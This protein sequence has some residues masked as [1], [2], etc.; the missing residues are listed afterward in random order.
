MKKFIGIIGSPSIETTN[1]KLLSL[2]K[3]AFQSEFELEL[4]SVRD[5]PMFN[6]PISLELPA[7]IQT[8][9]DKIDTADGVLISTAEYDHSVPAVLSNALA[10]LSYG[11]YPMVDK[12]TLILGTSYGRLGSSRAQFH[13]R[14]MLNAPQLAANMMSGD[15]YLL[16]HALR[17]FTDDSA[18]A[19]AI[20]RTDLETYINRFIEFV[21]HN[22]RTDVQILQAKEV[23][24]NYDKRFIRR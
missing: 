10:W 11:Q 5:W 7:K 19:R 20:D 13:L 18:F 17:A 4:I 12:P 3:H 22:K 6:K 8:V 14:Q 15:G 16:S 23:A 1:E 21:D 9:V 24:A 2:I